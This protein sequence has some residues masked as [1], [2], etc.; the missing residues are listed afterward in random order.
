MYIALRR[1][2]GLLLMQILLHQTHHTIGDFKEI[3]ATITSLSQ[4]SLKKDLH[5]FPELFLCGYPLQDLCLQRPFICKYLDFFNTLEEHLLSLDDEGWAAIVGGIDYALNCSQLPVSLKNSAYLLRPGKKIEKIYDKI[6]LPNYD[7]FD[8]KKYFTEGKIPC[9]LNIFDKKIGVLIC[10]DMWF[11]TNHIIDP[12]HLL[13]E[14]CDQE[15]I[16]LDFL[17]NLSG[18]PFHA[19]KQEKRLERGM[20]LSETFSA[21]FFYVNKVGGEDEILFDGRSF[22]ILGPKKI[23]EGK[24]FESDLLKIKLDELTKKDWKGC[25]VHAEAENTWESLFAP[26]LEFSQDKTHFPESSDEELSEILEGLIFGIREYASKCC[27]NHFLVALSGGIDSALVLTIAKLALKEGQTLEAIYMPGLYSQEMSYDL[28]KLLCENLKIPL[29]C[30]PIKF[31]HKSLSLLYQDY[32]KTSLSP[33]ADENIQSRIRGLLL[34]AHSNTK[35]LLVLNTSNKSE[36]A[37]GYST[38]YGDSVGALS[39]IGDLYKSEVYDLARFINKSYNNL[40]PEKII[41]RP[42][43]AELRENQRDDETLPP[44]DRLDALLEGILSYQVSHDNLLKI[45]KDKKELDFVYEL[46]LKS[47][48][49]RKQFC[50]ILKVRQKSFGFGY[51][52][53]ISKARTF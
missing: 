47:E 13:K 52:V 37:V 19:K 11:T 25:Q 6:L 36:L 8:E 31:I 5:I 46:Y 44:Y 15:K 27:M 33:L 32:M 35:N 45:A 12:V 48:Y 7:I 1:Q 23:I 38:L 51:R 49:K 43:S 9:V 29:K 16:Q 53:P 24:A 42:P 14:K 28:S 30:L 50:P 21:P 26:R 41:T 39:V 40:I 22:A 20:T 17:V 4:S 10:E 34:Y 2:Q 3:F 18:S